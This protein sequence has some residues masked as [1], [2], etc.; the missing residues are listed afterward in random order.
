MT[1]FE[2]VP[3][4]QNAFRHLCFVINS[5]FVICASSFSSICLSGQIPEDKGC[6]DVSESQD[7]S[8]SH[9]NHHGWQWPV[10]EGARAAAH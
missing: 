4:S 8:P 10:G 3:R 9:R 1:K 2:G 7:C 6:D 5:S